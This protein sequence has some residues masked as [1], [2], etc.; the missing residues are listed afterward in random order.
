M[1]H[2]HIA[3][4]ISA[5]IAPSEAVKSPTKVGKGASATAFISQQPCSPRSWI[6]FR[7]D[8]KK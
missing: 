3:R 1:S 4:F 5:G 8:P 2:E 6:G 7:P